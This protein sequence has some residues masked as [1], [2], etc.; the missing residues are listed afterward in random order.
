MSLIAT[1]VGTGGLV[2]VGFVPF[3]FEFGNLMFDGVIFCMIGSNRF[4]LNRDMPNNVKSNE[5]SYKTA[6]P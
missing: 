6:C 1:T 5:V 2:F 3:F 4:M